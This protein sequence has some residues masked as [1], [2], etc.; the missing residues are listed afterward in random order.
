MFGV[1]SEIAQHYG[2]DTEV[3]DSHA[4]TIDYVVASAAGWLTGTFGRALDV[5]GIQSA[6]D[7]LKAEVEGDI[8]DVDGVLL[9]TKILVAYQLKYTDDQYPKV[10]RAFNAHKE[11]CPAYMTV[12]DAVDFQL[13]L[14]QID[15]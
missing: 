10:K 14:I 7:R 4:T 2:I 11:K 5:R 12:R 8:N 3:H 13:T 6:P 15:E 9:I 1:H